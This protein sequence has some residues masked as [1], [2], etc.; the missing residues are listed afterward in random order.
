MVGQGQAN[1]EGGQQE[2]TVLPALSPEKEGE[3]GEGDKQGIE[4]IDL[5]DDGLG[6]ERHPHTEGERGGCSRRHPPAEQIPGREDR[7]HGQ[8]RIGGGGEVDAVGTVTEGQVREEMRE[9]YVGRV[10]GRVRHAEHT[11]LHLE[12]RHVEQIGRV[13]RQDSRRQ[14]SQVE[15]QHEYG[16]THAGEGRTHPRVA[17]ATVERRLHVGRK[18]TPAPKV[19]LAAWKT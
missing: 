17:F 3:Q 15:N 10:A 11:D 19:S 5:C 18:N 13:V 7:Q 6:P 16:D 12:H 4:G 2:V 8:R 14:R 9:Q 1:E